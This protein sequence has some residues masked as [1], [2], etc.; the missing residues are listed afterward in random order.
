[1]KLK[2]DKGDLLRLA[3]SA[4]DVADRR[5]SMPTLA[6]VRLEARG[7]VL[8]GV[9][10]D[11]YASS[12]L[13]VAC[14]GDEDG[15]CCVDAKAL[16][17]LAARMP[18]GPVSLGY[19]GRALAVRSGSA[20]YKLNA[21]PVDDF[22]PVPS[23]PEGG[24]EVSGALLSSLLSAVKP[25]MSTDD[26]R[27]HI[28]CVMLDGEVAVAT[29]GHRLHKREGGLGLEV[30][31]PPKGV[32]LLGKLAS[33]GDVT[34][35][36]GQGNLFAQQ[37]ERVVAVRLVDEAF[38]PYRKV[39]PD[40]GKAKQ[41]VT[42]ERSALSSALKRLS[43]L[44]PQS[45]AVRFRVEAGTLHL[46]TSDPDV[47]E[48]TEEVSCDATEASAWI[49]MNAKYMLDALGGA[50]GDEVGIRLMG[51]LDPVVIECEGYEAVCMPM[52]V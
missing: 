34:V 6:L 1:M 30:Q 29:D 49:G 23:M 9:A 10:T 13:T 8:E 11:L 45:Q 52:R 47:G 43:Y 3:S 7:G 16:K 42:V 19:D 38:P 50:V 41:V 51:E 37:G 5:S 35:A 26:S 25:A 24:T 12:L 28:A 14:D 32:E 40:R 20:R 27:P 33:D 39:I 22:P 44:S 18:E 36:V 17:D 31:V 48:G 46:A 2:I 15:A 21:L 4:A